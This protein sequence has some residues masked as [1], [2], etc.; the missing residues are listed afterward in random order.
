MWCLERW[1]IGVRTP[2]PTF[3]VRSVM[4]K[5]SSAPN[6]NRFVFHLKR[7][8]QENTPHFPDL[9]EAQPAWKLEEAS[10]CSD[11]VV[12]GGR[13]TEGWLSLSNSTS[14]TIR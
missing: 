4:S 14:K 12:V 6:E 2:T 1:R 7:I 11:L 8:Q 5:N 10:I 13:N 3:G 9:S